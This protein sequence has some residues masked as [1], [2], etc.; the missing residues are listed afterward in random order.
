[1]LTIISM[2]LVL[3][4]G[5]VAVSQYFKYAAGDVSQ[6]SKFRYMFLAFSITA[7]AIIQVLMVLSYPGR[8]CYL[9]YALEKFLK[10][11][12]MGEIVLLTQEM[13]DVEK[14]Y[15]SMF[16]SVVSYAALMLFFID[17]L[18]QGGTL[19]MSRFGVYFNPVAPW[20]KALYFVFYMFYVVMLITFVVYRGA[21]VYRR[22]E[23]H[24]L[25]LLLAVYVFSAAGFISEQFI[26]VYSMTYVPIV[27]IFNMV[28]VILMRHLLVY[29]DSITITQRHFARELDESRTDVVFVLDSQLRIVYQNKR[30]E[31]LSQLFSDQ[32]V[33]RKITDVFEFTSSAYS[34]ICQTGEENAFGI[35]A[36][37]PMSDRHVN[38]IINHK[39]DNYGEILA[40]V[41]FVY[42]MEDIEK[43]ESVVA[44]ITEENEEEMIKNAVNIT[45]DA[46][47]LIIDEDIVFLNVFQRVL[48]PYKVNVTRA[49]SGNDALDQIESHVYDIIFVAYEMEK[50]SGTQIVSKVRSMPG[51]YYSQ[52][53]IVFTTTA[54]IN[55]VFT[56]FLEAGFNDYLEKPLSKRALNSVLTRWLWQRF[57]NEN[58][59]EL[60]K[61]NRFSAQYNELNEL[62]T[63]AEKMFKEK[64]YEMLGFCVKGI[65][66]DSKILELTDL[67]DLSSEL[68]EAIMFFDEERI[69][70]LFNKL[71]VGIRD[72]ITIR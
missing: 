28:A 30:A 25:M 22:C 67:A 7:S 68:L 64:K 39:L 66:R 4:A 51:D 72:A 2:C 11:L 17:S 18:M 46:R 40:M 62:I 60:S 5:L 52:V 47:V 19:E 44:D 41:V 56:G 21:A 26:I 53:P 63:D 36:D 61:E 55:D 33:G 6:K 29:H 38:M 16:I 71:R 31:V 42:N 23:K 50:M 14:K 12:T 24:D 58:V 27:I 43:A 57:G 65:E 10:V 20:H 35:S 32:Y 3:T 70:Q 15:T 8:L 69:E 49:V 48:K 45:R 54:D 37:Y 59:E 34:Q 13:V 9:L 1:M